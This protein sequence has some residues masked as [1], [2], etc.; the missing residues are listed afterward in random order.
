MEY[1][2]HVNNTQFRVM[3][4]PDDICL[5]VSLGGTEKEGCYLVFRGDILDVQ[6]LINNA[7]I[8]I[9]KVKIHWESQNN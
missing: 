1:N 8:A 9:D 4:E 7:K 3:K 6:E 2:T 5:R